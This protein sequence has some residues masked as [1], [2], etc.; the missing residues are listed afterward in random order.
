MFHI[1]DGQSIQQSKY[2]RSSETWR[3]AEN[4]TLR[5]K[6]ESRK[7]IC[8]ERQASCIHYA[9]PAEWDTRV[10]DGSGV[11]SEAGVCAIASGII[12][13]WWMKNGLVS[14][15]PAVV[16]AMARAGVHQEEIYLTP[17]PSVRTTRSLCIRYRDTQST[18]TT[19]DVLVL[20][21]YI[22]HSFKEE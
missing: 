20:K 15:L 9:S 1:C 3:C 13:N 2:K 19:W 17:V 11:S 5:H 12:K 8:V 4:N 21:S 6:T 14:G 18:S 10:H 22:K 7:H 16:G